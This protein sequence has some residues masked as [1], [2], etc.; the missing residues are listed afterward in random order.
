MTARPIFKT[1]LHVGE[2]A[3]PVKI[4]AAVEDQRVH[5]RLLHAEDLQ[6]VTQQLVNTEDDARPPAA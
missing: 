3:L 5:F 4:F 1:T 2:L 6:P